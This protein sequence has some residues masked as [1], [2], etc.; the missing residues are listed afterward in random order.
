MTDDLAPDPTPP[1]DLGPEGELTRA[2]TLVGLFLESHRGLIR[3]LSAVHSAHGLQ[4]KEFDALLRLHRSPGQMLRMRDLAAQVGLSTSGATTLVERLL[5][6]G[7][8]NRETDPDDRRSL[9]V[10]L[11]T[12][13]RDL[14]SADL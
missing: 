2:L 8:V 3:E 4:G 10:R 6:R 7:W 14:L 5:A 11:T 13:G 9:L 12:S 1:A